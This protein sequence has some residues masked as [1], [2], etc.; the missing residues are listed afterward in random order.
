MSKRYGRNQKRAARETIA[1]LQASTAQ[2][3]EGLLMQQGIGAHMR[4]KIETMQS[5]LDDV[6]RGLGQ[7]FY[8]LPPVKL[9]IEEHQDRFRMP[10]PIPASELM[11]R[12]TDQISSLVSSAVYDLQLIK[13]EVARDKITG[14]VHVQLETPSGRKFYALSGSAWESIRND[15]KRLRQ[16]LVPMIADEMA[17]FIARGER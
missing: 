3:N 12:D 16:Q 15:E 1:S 13:S 17:K 10:K 9:R 7:Y 14:A 6:A 5:A 4:S 8:G 2:L 11:F